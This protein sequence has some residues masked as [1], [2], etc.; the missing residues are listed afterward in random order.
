MTE[1]EYLTPEEVSRY[2]RFSVNSVYRLISR[3][4][5]E[6]YK[7]GRFWRIKRSHLEEFAEALGEREELPDDR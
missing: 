2:L 5:L 4:E 1:E 7:Q 6:A 3:G